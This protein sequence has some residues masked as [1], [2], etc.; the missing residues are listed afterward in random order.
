MA[1]SIVRSLYTLLAGALV[2]STLTASASESADR[3]LLHGRIYTA[4]P[5]DAV[6]SAI[7]IRGGR[8]VYVGDDAGA[9]ALIGTKTETTDLNGRFVMPGLVDGHMHPLEAGAK[10]LKCSLDYEPLTVPEF[11]KRIQRCLDHDKQKDPNAWLQVVAWFQQAMLPA[12]VVTSRETLDTLHTTRPIVVTDSFGHTVLVNSKALQLAKITRDSKDPIGGVI[13]HNAHGEPSGILQDAA[14]E[15]VDAL[16]PKMTT[17]AAIAAAHAASKAM[18]KQGVTSFLDAAAP[19]ESLQA[20]ATLASTQQLTARAHFA[21]V[22]D[23]AEADHPKEQV[24]RIVALRKQFDQGALSPAP[25][26]TVRNAKL[27][28]DGVIAGPAFTGS[29]LTPYLANQGTPEVPRWADSGNRGPDPYFPAEKLSTIVLELAAN[30]IDPHMHVDGDRAVRA[31]LDSIEV[32]RKTQ[33]T[34]DIRPGFAHCEIVAP[35]DYARFAAL[36][37]YPVLSFQ[38][39]KRAPDTVDQLRDYMGPARAAIL[40][41]AGVL[42]KAGAQITFGSDWPVDALDE[43]FALKVAVTRENAA[44]AGAKFAGRLG[45]DPGLTTREALRA[46]TIGASNALHQDQV[47]GSLELGKFADLIVLDRDVLTIEPADIANVKVLE[48]VLGGRTVYR[49]PSKQS[50]RKHG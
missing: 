25:G 1:K 23:P 11:Q 12:G 28:I 30:G 48:T 49:Q 7:A 39:E 5:E 33:P 24:A 29:M 20:F 16:L 47:T 43:W 2:F 21:P 45:T 35:E 6:K 18:A 8:I 40:E 42:A 46:I 4:N 9:Q 27:F 50:S 22:I 14:A 17:K 37:V 10:L 41:P 3:V 13:E 26:L 34:A 36:K 19:V 31:A 15:P 38:W 44:S 32:L